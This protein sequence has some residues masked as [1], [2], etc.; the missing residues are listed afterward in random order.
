MDVYK[1]FR[2]PLTGEILKIGYDNYPDNPRKVWDCMGEFLVDAS[3]RY[4]DNESSIKLDFSGKNDDEK[5][6]DNNPDVMAYLPVYVYDHSGACMNTTG[7]SC[8]WDSGQ[9]GWLICTRAGLRRAGYGDWKRITKKRRELI[10]NWLRNEVITYSAYMSGDVY[11][12]VIKD[13]AGN[14]QDSVWGFYGD[15][16]LQAIR[17]EYPEFTEERA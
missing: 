17:D 15:D 7:F 10:E 9:I 13:A 4:I 5:T 14:T 3:C 12:Y 1:K 8:P 11:G 2:N 6:L 16:G